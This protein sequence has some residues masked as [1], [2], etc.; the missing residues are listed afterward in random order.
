MDVQE[1]EKAKGGRGEG[2][3]ERGGEREGDHDHAGRIYRTVMYV[4]THTGEGGG[5]GGRKKR[6]SETRIFTSERWFGERQHLNPKGASLPACLGFHLA[7]QSP[8]HR[9]SRYT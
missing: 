5:G 4:C 2:G 9:G 1:R 6:F 3:G 8:Y 7:L